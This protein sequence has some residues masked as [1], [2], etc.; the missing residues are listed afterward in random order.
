MVCVTR[1]LGPVYE[2]VYLATLEAGVLKRGQVVGALSSLKRFGQGPSWSPVVT[3]SQSASLKDALVQD[4]CRPGFYGFNC[5]MT[6]GNCYR[7]RPCHHGTGRCNAQSGPICQAGFRGG[8]CTTS[9]KPDTVDDFWTMIWQEDVATIVMLTNLRESGKRKCHQYWPNEDDVMDSRDLQIT[10]T[11]EK[12]YN[13]FTLRYFTVAD[14]IEDEERQIVQ[15]H[16]T[17]WPDHGVPEALGLQQFH[18]VVMKNTSKSQGPLLVHCS[19]GI[20]R[21]GTYIGLDV[22]LRQGQDTGFINVS[23]YV[24]LM[25]EQRMNMVQTLVSN[26]FLI[27]FTIS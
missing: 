7:N 4:L 11:K 27:K 3:V 23:N 24:A 14:E 20:G 1:I 10:C 13:D 26:V 18:Q 19:A 15:Y 25:R 8:M 9:P 2:D 22:L 5:S 6:C 12:K 17:S 16:Y 21:T